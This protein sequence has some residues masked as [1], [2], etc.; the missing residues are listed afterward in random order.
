MTRRTSCNHARW[1][2]EPPQIRVSDALAQT[3][4]NEV[5]SVQRRAIAHWKHLVGRDH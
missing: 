5:A 2:L 4:S 1:Q 3:N